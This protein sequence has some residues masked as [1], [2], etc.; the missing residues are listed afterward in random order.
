MIL[1][2]DQSVYDWKGEEVVENPPAGI[3][4]EVLT[5]MG[6]PDRFSEVWQLLSGESSPP[7]TKVVTVGKLIAPYVAAGTGVDQAKSPQCYSIAAKLYAGGKVELSNS[8]VEVI[9]LA[10]QASPTPQMWVKGLVQ[11]LLDPESCIPAERA[12]FEKHYKRK[13]FPN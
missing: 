4:A 6:K 2:A 11:Y 10:V 13:D 12:V 3:L 5:S 7:S 8:D 9:K 1:D